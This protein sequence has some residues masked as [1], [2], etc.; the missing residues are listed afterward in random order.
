MTASALFNMSF[1]LTRKANYI[2]YSQYFT[3]WSMWISLFSFLFIAILMIVKKAWRIQP[4]SLQL[5]QT[6]ISRVGTI[7][8]LI[9]YTSEII[10]TLMY[11]ANPYRSNFK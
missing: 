9:A 1:W 4:P 11:W 6:W 7:A 2:D 5:E 10:V 8:F 3:Y